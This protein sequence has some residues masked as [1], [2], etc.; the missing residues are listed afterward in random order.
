M[1]DIDS[2]QEPLLPDKSNPDSQTLQIDKETET[3]QAAKETETYVTNSRFVN[4]EKKV[5]QIIEYF[6]LLESP[7]PDAEALSDY[8]NDLSIDDDEDDEDDEYSHISET[9]RQPDKGKKRVRDDDEQGFRPATRIRPNP[10][11]H[12][13]EPSIP[14][15]EPYDGIPKHLKSFL[16]SLNLCF[17]ASPSK[18]ASDRIKIIVAGRL[19]VGQ[20]VHPWWDTWK[21]HWS[22][23]EEGYQTWEDFERAIRARFKDHMEKKNAQEKFKRSKQT[24]RLSE[25][26]SHMQSLNLVAGYPERIEWET[27]YDGLKPKLKEMWAMKDSRPKDL[28]ARYNQL[29]KLSAVL[30]DIESEQRRS[31]GDGDKKK[32]EKEK[33]KGKGKEKENKPSSKPQ[34][35]VKSK[36]RVPTEIWSR[37]RKDGLC[38]RCGSGKHLIKDCESEVIISDA[39]DD[40]PKVSAISQPEGPSDRQEKVSAVRTGKIFDS[41]EDDYLDYSSDQDWGSNQNKDFNQDWSLDD[42]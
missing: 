27:V 11:V 20:K 9:V 6:R 33:E 18:Y 16:E 19:C 37:R 40:K 30:D 3:L 13:K 15:P 26:I 25:Y 38:M 5:D 21:E 1:S 32:K 8:V 34:K 22:K 12:T 28:Q 36:A 10:M 17:W 24:G 31:A 41:E 35:E 7:K 29:V 39:K 42:Y 2:H 14:L 23:G 4:L